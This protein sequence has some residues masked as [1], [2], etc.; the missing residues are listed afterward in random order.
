MQKE[1]KDKVYYLLSGLE[2][3]EPLPES[4]FDGVTESF[5]FKL[6]GMY[7]EV[8]KAF[9]GGEG[10]V[11]TDS[12]LCL[13]PIEELTQINGDYKLLME[14]IPD[15]FLFGKDAA[16]TGYA[17]HKTYGTFHS[18]GL[19]SNFETDNI[20]LLGNDFLRFL[21]YLESYRYEG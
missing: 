15:Y 16:D 12:W 13:F 1:I 9:N 14:Q 6:P 11:G 20:E 7:K 19:M 3:E 4:R 17:F 18:F 10:E 2:K 5:D 21:E 8:M